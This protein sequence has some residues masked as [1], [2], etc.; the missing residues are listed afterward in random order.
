MMGIVFLSTI[1]A[2]ASTATIK[3]RT[4]VADW[5]VVSLGEDVETVQFTWAVDGVTNG[6]TQ[7]KV[8]IS[9]G[10]TGVT[11]PPFKYSCLPTECAAQTFLGTNIMPGLK[12]R[13]SYTWCANVETSSGDNLTGC[14]DFETA[15]SPQTFPGAAQWIGGG[16]QLRS[17]TGLVLTTK[18]KKARAFVS[19]VGAFYLYV[20]G[21]KI[22][23]QVM[24]PLQSVYPKTIYY[25]TFDITDVLT[26]GTNTIGAVLGNVK[27]GY[28]DLWCNMTAAGGPDGCR[29]FVVRIEADG[30]VLDTSDVSTWEARTG[31]ITWDH[32]FH[33]ETFDATVPWDWGVK[34]SSNT[35]TT[36]IVNDASNDAS[37][38]QTWMKAK[39]MTPPAGAPLTMEVSSSL[40]TLRPNLGPPVTTQRELPAQTDPVKTTAFDVG[41]A[42][43]F[44]FGDNVAGMARLDLSVGHGLPAGTALRVAIAEIIEGSFEDVGGM[45]A[46]CPGCGACAGGAGGSNGNT[47][48]SVFVGDGAL[49][50]T[51]CNNPS[52]SGKA[53]DTHALR[54]EPCYPHQS[55]NKGG[56]V[57][58]YD[59]R[60]S[61]YIGDFNNANMTNVYYVRGDGKAESYTPFFAGGGFRYAQLSIS[62]GKSKSSDV[63][64]RI[65]AFTPDKTTLTGLDMHSSV[66]SAGDVTVATVTSVGKGIVPDVLNKI[67]AMTRASQLSN[68]WGI[69]TDCPQ[70]ERRGWTGD[71]Q[72]SSDEAMLNFDMRGFYAK[73]LRDMMD[74][75]S[76]R[77]P[78]VPANESGAIADV[79]P[80]DGI[81]GLPGCPVWQV[82]YTVVG[83]GLWKH[84]GE[85]ALPLLKFHYQNMRNLSMWFERHADPTDNLL[86]TQC[87]GD[88]MG[89][90]PESHNSGSSALTPTAAV[91]AFYH[92]LSRQY[93]SVIAA[94]L[95][96]DEEAKH[97]GTLR[98]EGVRAYHKR[99]YNATA[100]GYN[101]C[102]NDL[103]QWSVHHPNTTCHGTSAHGSQT[104]N[105]MAL[106]IGAPQSVSPELTMSI[107]QRLASDVAN[108]GDK[109]TTGV[110]GIAWLLPQLDIFGNGERAM[111]TMMGDQYPSL[112]TMAAQNMTSLCE[113]LACSFHTAGG[114][115]QNRESRSLFSLSLSLFKVFLLPLSLSCLLVALTTYHLFPLVS[116]SVF[117]YVLYRHHA[118]RVGCMVQ[119]KSWW[120]RLE[121]ERKHRGMEDRH[122][123]RR[124]ERHHDARQR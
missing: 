81:G 95:G 123:A 106:A 76:R 93:M 119:R 8:V 114:G 113:N 89:F 59:Q 111:K 120:Y 26:A 13:T 46:L 70:R 31:P 36:T 103:P 69:P 121:S 53:P 65:A 34:S 17:T 98:N 5:G 79:V 3:L 22:G 16:G 54:D 124:T 85:A 43:I 12:A 18:P 2:A 28:D 92:V 56:E 11:P 58:H 115:S 62:A 40:G 66:P 47:E 117:V 99:F 9:V 80:Y 33:G 21:E 109:F 84:Y 102:V 29:A 60:S 50:N 44:D 32:F 48:C 64:A 68:L 39:V 87:Y 77:D 75:Q 97:W 90:N 78:N 91:T 101:P 25:S 63:E 107:A 30:E 122:R 51:Y 74:D 71:A 73:Y 19:G 118:R 1:R 10:P 105:A 20:N 96:D 14:L 52:R 37:N 27:W 6:A 112:G 23:N 116:S 35:A 61:R 49:C 108:F 72:S 24:A 110:S 15:P 86:V 7:K 94:A 38:T 45:C 88:W 57:P 42:Y 41:T 55:Y 104:S 100:G 4:G 83:H 82:V 67:H